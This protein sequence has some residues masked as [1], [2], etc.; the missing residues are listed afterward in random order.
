MNTY[1]EKI[2]EETVNILKDFVFDESKSKVEQVEDKLVDIFEPFLNSTE[3]VDYWIDVKLIDDK[4]FEV[5]I[6]LQKGE[7][8][9]TKIYNIN[10]FVK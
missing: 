9:D 5:H 7:H 1:I 10:C 2:K 8:D 3:L 6:G 4:T